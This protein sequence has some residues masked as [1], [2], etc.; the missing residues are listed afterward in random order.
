MAKTYDT[1]VLNGYRIEM[2]NIEDTYEKAI[3]KYDYPYKDGADLEDMGQKAHII[4]FRCFFYDAADKED[5]IGTA[6]NSYDDHILLLNDLAEMELITFDHPKYGLMN[7]HIES[8]SVRHDDRERC[9]ELDITFVEQ[10]RGAVAITDQPPILSSLET[11]YAA[12]QIQQAAKLAADIKSVLP[13]ADAGIVSKTLDAAQGLLSQAQEFSAKARSFVDSVESYISI[14]EA[15]VNQV[16]SPINSLQASIAYVENLPGRIT[17]SIANAIEKTALLYDSIRNQPAQFIG[18]LKT[19]FDDIIAEFQEFGE[20]DPSS[21]ASDTCAVMTS[22]LQLACAQRM[23]LE[24]A[25]IYNTDETAYR[26][27]DEDVQIMDILK[28]EETLSVAR[29]MI[30]EAVENAREGD[31]SD[32]IAT[33]KT[34]ASALLNHVDRVR[35]E[36]ES[37]VEITLDN[38]TPLHL[39]CLMRGLPYTDAERL[40]KIN[41]IRH[42]NFTNGKVLVYAR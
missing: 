33:L 39:I 32:L 40:L 37:M 15:D 38:P 16:V 11:A 24:T 18:E 35:I 28:L 14:A 10:M 23:A 5:W 19:A 27:G 13:I 42:P 6:N 30:E 34:M 26:E 4:K 2:E 17:G 22:H 21:I 8:V 29:E 36:R 12:G 20:D 41:R 3:A 25:D 31:G 1:G 7:G 9:A